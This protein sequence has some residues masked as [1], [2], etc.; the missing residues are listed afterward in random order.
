MTAIQ[1]FFAPPLVTHV[2]WGLLHS[3]WKIAGVSRRG[4][5][6]AG[7]PAGIVGLAIV[8]LLGLALG[9]APGARAGAE[10]RSSVNGLVVNADGS[11]AA[12]VDLWLVG[13]VGAGG[14]TAVLGTGR[15]ERDGRFHVERRE[16]TD[17]E[18][19]S[20]QI[21]LFAHRA[22]A[23]LGW[24]LVA[25][26]PNAPAPSDSI[27]VTL[28]PL[29]EA[30]VAILDPAGKPLGGVLVRPTSFE[31]ASPSLPDE[32]SERLGATTDPT[33]H[34][35]VRAISPSGVRGVRVITR[36]FGAQEIYLLNGGLK[37]DDQLRL[38]PVARVE[39][40][41]TATDP[42]DA[43]ERKVYLGTYP[44]EFHG[45][46]ATG[47]AEAVTDRDGRFTVPALAEGFLE[48]S[49]SLPR[50][51]RERVLRPR[52]SLLERGATLALKV[53]LKRLVR[54]QGIVQEK[55]TGTTVAGVAVRFGSREAAPGTMLPAAV[56]DAEGRFTA[57]A[58][59]S[60]RAEL[61]VDPP[62][63]YLQM[64]RAIDV[65]VGEENGQVLA[66][67][68]LERGAT[69]RGRV[70]DEARNPVAGAIVKGVWN[71]FIGPGPQ[72]GSS[73]SARM[74]ATAMTDEVGSFV[75]EGIDREASVSLEASAGDASTEGTTMGEPG[76]AE[77][78]TLRISPRNTV[79][80]S[81]RVLDGAGQPIEGA[82]VRLYSR[83]SE[84]DAI[85]EPGFLQFD[86]V[87]EIRTGADGRFSTPRQIR[88]G[89]AYR[90][91]AVAA[92]RLEDSTPWLF[93]GPTTEPTFPDLTLNAK[94]GR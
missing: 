92:G 50:D 18:P 9:V 42:A 91:E 64:N 82:R 29:R 78:V 4:K 1:A 69:L 46:E 6:P 30:A 44:R 87:D 53:P 61:F 35:S 94:P 34:A 31:G 55:G 24:K 2:G 25:K 32:L 26:H 89:Y 5:R 68:E 80:L 93:L 15:S 66:P 63:A 48:V 49:V 28:A 58:L 88:R 37:G 90:A 45:V 71:K 62:N 27:K 13:R 74:S 76:R 3:V 41:V 11:P 40:I 33:G 59:P 47:R 19:L 36:A 22:G 10:P 75:L 81:G 86:E 7:R 60:P 73:V 23:G 51:S 16:W 79:A 20:G 65:V 14:R 85:P 43:A 84:R 72:R 83:G 17:P 12:D 77:L 38:K 8:A 52:P 54:V 39:G 21:V 57:L 56:T 70:V 67:V